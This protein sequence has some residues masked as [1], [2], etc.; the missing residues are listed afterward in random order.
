MQRGGQRERSAGRAHRTVGGVGRPG[1]W[2]GTRGH[3]ARAG[4]RP[5]SPL[6]GAGAGCATGNWCG[7]RRKIGGAARHLVPGPQPL[8]ANPGCQP[9]PSPTTDSPAT[10]PGAPRAA[11]L[12]PGPGCSCA[13]APAPRKPRRAKRMR[14]ARG[15]CNWRHCPRAFLPLRHATPAPSVAT[16]PAF[17]CQH[18]APAPA[19]QAPECP[20]L[21]SRPQV[22]SSSFFLQP[23]PQCLPPWLN[24]LRRTHL[25]KECA[26]LNTHAGASVLQRF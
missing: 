4:G 21:P 12:H 2:M 14:T 23:V 22:S 17:L 9:A 3:R 11:Q 25:I 18:S 10:A 1:D 24:T 6:S 13:S 15:T 16:V 7:E 8:A 26:P 5:R 20:R 19:A